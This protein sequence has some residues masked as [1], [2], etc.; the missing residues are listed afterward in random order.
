MSR[1]IIKEM[2]K[3]REPLETKPH[4]DITTFGRRNDSMPRKIFVKFIVPLIDRAPMRGNNVTKQ[5][6]GIAKL[7]LHFCAQ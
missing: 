2:D 4:L 1:F 7:F 3:T 6:N 5:A